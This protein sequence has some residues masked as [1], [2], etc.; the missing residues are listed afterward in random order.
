MLAIL[1]YGWEVRSHIL[2][3]QGRGDLCVF[4]ILQR[5]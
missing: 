2:E 4:A 1:L 3:I 5:C